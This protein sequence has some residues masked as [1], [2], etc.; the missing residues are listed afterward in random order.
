MKKSLWIAGATVLLV[1]GSV[2]IRQFEGIATAQATKAK[3]AKKVMAAKV[4]KG[5]P[6]NPAKQ[7]AERGD[8]SRW[9]GANNDGISLE[10]GLLTEWPEGG[11]PLAW[12]TKGLGDGFS[13]V[14]VAGGKV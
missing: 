3:A 2:A 7:E 8:W 6:S 12:R 11:P 1:C 4:G 9:R 14:V 10:T 5:S 13:S